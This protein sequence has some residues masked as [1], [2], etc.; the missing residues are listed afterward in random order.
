MKPSPV[1]ANGACSPSHGEQKTGHIIP[2]YSPAEVKTIAGVGLDATAFTSHIS[3]NPPSHVSGKQPILLEHILNCHKQNQPL[4]AFHSPTGLA[5]C[6]QML[7]GD[8][9][10]RASS[11]PTLLE[12]CLALL[13]R[14]QQQPVFLDEGY[15]LLRFQK[16]DLATGEVP[17]L[18]GKLV[19]ADPK[20]KEIAIDV[21]EMAPEYDGE[22][23]STDNL[24][25]CFHAL[26]MVF[27]GQKLSE[28]RGLFTSA[29][30]IGRSATLLCMDAIDNH[31]QKAL[32]LPP[33]LLE[34]FN[35]SEID[36]MLNQAIDTARTHGNPHFV[37]TTKQ[38][39]EL[40]AACRILLA[41][42]SHRLAQGR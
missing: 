20:G 21:L 17:T 6:E 37:H 36:R 28:H 38:K 1:A 25:K 19:I 3:A 29:M 13:Q 31:I 41:N 4:I 5:R 30:G 11:Y 23:L 2:Q 15:Q 35:A 32:E 34:N 10:L 27:P 7:R 33:Y 42:N 12:Q 24:V 22:A 40:A 18:S 14:N 9:P 8:T 26:R 39:E 16:N